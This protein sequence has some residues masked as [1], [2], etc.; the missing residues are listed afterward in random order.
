MVYAFMRY[1]ISVSHT[2]LRPEFPTH[3]GRGKERTMVDICY[4]IMDLE[5]Y[6]HITQEVLS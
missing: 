2:V 4:G 5:D 6:Q 1:P 3:A